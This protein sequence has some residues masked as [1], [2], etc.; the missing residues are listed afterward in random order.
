MNERIKELAEQVDRE[1]TNPGPDTK[2]SNGSPS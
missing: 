1:F 2:Q